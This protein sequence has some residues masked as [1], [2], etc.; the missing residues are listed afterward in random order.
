[1]KFSASSLLFVAVVNSYGKNT[2]A[3]QAQAQVVEAKDQDR[4]LMA[5]L[6]EKWS[7]LEPAFNVAGLDFTFD[8]PVSNFVD[9]NQA[10]YELYDVNCKE[11][12]NIVST[13]FTSSLV[14][15]TAGSTPADDVNFAVDGKTAR[16]NIAIDSG[17]I[18]SEPDVY[19]EITT[20]DGFTNANITFCVRFGLDTLG[21]PPIGV[22]F[23]ETIVT[24][25]IDLSSGFSV[26]AIAVEPKDQIISTA[27]GSYALEGYI[28]EPGTDTEVP[29]TSIAFTQGS[30]ITVC[31]KPDVDG[32]ADGIKMRTIDS[33]LWARDGTSQV[34][35]ESAVVVGNLLTIFDDVACVGGDYCQFSSILFAAFYATEGEVSGTGVASM[36]FGTGRRR[37]GLREGQE[38]EQT[39]TRA[40]EL[41]AAAISEFDIEISIES[42]D[43]RPNMFS[44]G[45]ITLGKTKCASVLGLLGV[46][47]MLL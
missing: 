8:Y 17:T 30:L 1:M 43:D 39:Q 12:G 11:G 10:Y 3:E 27:I 42:T 25:N 4:A 24:L 41:E 33:F 13:G 15:V 16:V 26:D 9:Q 36:Q 6:A 34:A 37:R 2:M 35:I 18:T 46:A 21:N 5:S 23:L 7:I 29:D 38:Q 28:C 19:S 32:V 31:V 45:A 40:L 22:N 47:A 44:A 14:D 20:V